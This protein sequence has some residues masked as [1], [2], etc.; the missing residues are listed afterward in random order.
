[1]LGLNASVGSAARIAGPIVA[2]LLFQH[3]GVAVPLV[4]G[5]A[6]FAVCA[7]AAIRVRTSPSPAAV[8]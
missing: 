5:A 7:A 3:A 1:V 8:A 6:L 4:V 2:T